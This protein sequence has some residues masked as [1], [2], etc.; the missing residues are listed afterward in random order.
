[1]VGGEA[2]SG[3]RS[4]WHG[5]EAEAFQEA[6][7][8]PGTPWPSTKQRLWQSLLEMGMEIDKAE[9]GGGESGPPDPESLLLLS[10]CGEPRSGGGAS[11][12]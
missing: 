10:S 6:A 8:V 7:S 12:P 5:K 4:S 11:A 3:C 2:S 1:M 9:Q